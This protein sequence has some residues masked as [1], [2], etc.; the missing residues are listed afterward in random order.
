MGIEYD[1]QQEQVD[2]L[3]LKQ[4]VSIGLGISVRATVEKMQAQN[5]HCAI[6]TEDGA[7]VGIFTDRD[8]IRRIIDAPE[9]W[10]RPI[11]DFMTPSPLTVKSKDS[12]N[13]ALS[14]MNREH[15]RN[16]PV[17]DNK[18]ILVGNL[19]HY[20]IISYLAERFSI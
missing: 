10:H 18:G 1:L 20:A 11:D 5:Q 14:L 4:F 2:Q 15:L 3:D 6:I 13:A 16:V 12:V 17:V 9:T 19:S 8:V 7:P